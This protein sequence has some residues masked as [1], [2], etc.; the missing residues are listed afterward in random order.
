MSKNR[1]LRFE[2]E[3]L[4]FGGSVE[5]PLFGNRIASVAL[6]DMPGDGESGDDER[7]GGSL[8]F[9]ASAVA[10]DAEDFAAEGNRLLPDFEVPQASCH[11]D[12]IAGAR[13]E[14]D[15]KTVPSGAN[16]RGPRSRSSAACE[17]PCL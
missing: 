15:I 2:P 11:G 16:D 6:G 17:N 13:G 12:T 4:S 1:K 3:Q 9:P 5:L 7:V 8:G 10:H 14:R